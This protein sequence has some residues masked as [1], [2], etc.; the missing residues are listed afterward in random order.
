MRG[1]RDSDFGQSG[2]KKRELWI[3]IA[4]EMREHGY[5]IAAERVSKKWHN[6]MI[7]YTKNQSK[8]HGTIN[9]E[10]YDDIKA[11]Y[12]GKVA[13]DS[14]D[15]TD[16]DSY[17]TPLRLDHLEQ[18]GVDLQPAKRKRHCRDDNFESNR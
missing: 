6:L 12:D 8:R 2:A 18:N 16:D 7:T 13:Q 3:E 9:W 14:V 1:N 11:V 15:S 10:F 5:N 17:L 4:N